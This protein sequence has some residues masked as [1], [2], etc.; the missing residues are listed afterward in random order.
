MSIWNIS[1]NLTQISACL[2]LT[3]EISHCAF[4]FSF[5]DNFPKLRLSY[6]VC[7]SA[8]GLL[9]S[10]PTWL[11]VVSSLSSFQVCHKTPGGVSEKPTHEQ[12]HLFPATLPPSMAT[13]RLLARVQSEWGAWIG[14]FGGGRK[15][16]LSLLNEGRFTQYNEG[17]THGFTADVY[18]KR[19]G[20]YC[21]GTEGFICRYTYPLQPLPPT[22]GPELSAGSLLFLFFF[23][24]LLLFFFF[25]LSESFGKNVR[26]HQFNSLRVCVK[27]SQIK[28]HQTGNR[29]GN[30]ANSTD[31]YSC[32]SEIRSRCWC[33]IITLRSRKNKEV[34]HVDA[35]RE[36]EREG[37]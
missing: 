4:L 31:V 22:W 5:S 26:L 14:V 36:R 21:F 35:H 27:S 13:S 23:F 25:Y 17:W 34:I 3:S 28:I 15:E 6:L 24:L 32:R 1:N 10:L 2:I 30:S 12:R 7:L 8:D 29:R 37:G 18:L 9:A 19:P 33:W 11:R 20:K 16:M